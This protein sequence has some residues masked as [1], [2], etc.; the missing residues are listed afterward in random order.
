[1]PEYYGTLAKASFH[2]DHGQQ[3]CVNRIFFFFFFQALKPITAQQKKKSPERLN[4]IKI[5]K[6]IVQFVD[7]LMLA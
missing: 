7:K 5:I 6:I 4:T 1:M 3:K 2:M